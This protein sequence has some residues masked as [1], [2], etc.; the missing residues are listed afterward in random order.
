[1]SFQMSFPCI[2]SSFVFATFRCFECCAPR[3]LPSVCRSKP[4]S[5]VSIESSDHRCRYRFNTCSTSV[6]QLFGRFRRS[7]GSGTWFRDVQGVL[8]NALRHKNHISHFWSHFFLLYYIL[9]CML[10]FTCQI[11]LA[12]F[13][14]AKNHLPLLLAQTQR[15]TF[16]AQH[17][18]AGTFAYFRCTV[19]NSP[20]LFRIPNLKNLHAKAT[21]YMYIYIYINPY[22][23]TV[24]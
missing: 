18:A 3:P 1:M 7:H 15:Q 2:G 24:D 5:T 6:V 10:D 13:A 17:S 12:H 23:Y 9:F 4:R 14:P 22:F 21:C 8:F 19:S 20:H 16:S 11:Q